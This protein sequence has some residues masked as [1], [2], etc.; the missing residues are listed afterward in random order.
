MLCIPILGPSFAE[1][2]KQIQ[3]ASKLDCAVELRLDLFT[4]VQPREIRKLTESCVNP[5]IFTLRPESQGGFFKGDHNSRLDLIREIA[6]LS[7]TSIPI[8]IDL[9]YDTPIDFIKQLKQ[10]HPHVCV[11]LSYHNFQETPENL[12]SILAMLKEKPAEIYKFSA[13]TNSVIDALRLLEFQQNGGNNLAAMG[14]GPFG[15]ITRVLGKIKGSRLVY[16]SLNDS[17]Q[18]ASGQIS[19]EVLLDTY[20]FRSQTSSTTIYGLIGLPTNKS[21]GNLFHNAMY[22]DVGLGSVYLKMDV[23][24][25]ELADFF[26]LAKKLDFQGLSVTMPLKENILPWISEMDSISKEIGAVN[27]ISIQNGELLGFN[28]DGFGA[29]EAIEEVEELSG[30]TILVLGAGGAA[31]AIVYTAKQRGAHVIV[32]NRTVEKADWLAET[33]G[34]TAGRLENAQEYFLEGV[35]IVVNCTPESMPIDKNI[36]LGNA[37]V[38]DMRN[39][40]VETEFL[41][42]AKKQGCRVIYGYQMYVYQALKQIEIWFGVKQEKSAPVAKKIIQGILNQVKR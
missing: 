4:S 30:K 10:D 36:P 9:E 26:P 40:P 20:R 27:T 24:P 23:K 35:D 1:A 3:T 22:G 41:L 34:C 2:Q 33:M 39:I 8:Y 5:L 16:A 18:T 6:A 29:I 37:L 42:N 25:D 13:M 11:I 21:F 12:E 17:L 14:M 15:Y 31:K 7:P 32:L 28:T 19:A 38:M